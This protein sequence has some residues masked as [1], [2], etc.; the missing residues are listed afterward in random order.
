MKAYGGMDVYIHIFL[1]SALAGGKSSISRP[2]RFTPVEKAPG[3][4]WIGD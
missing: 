1:I 4:H 3:I 2:G